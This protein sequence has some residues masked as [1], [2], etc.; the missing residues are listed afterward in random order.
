[1]SIQPF[2]SMANPG[3]ASGGGGSGLMTLLM[4]GSV[5]A[6]F[7]FMILRPQ[8]KQADQRKAMIEALKRGDK[9]VTSG[10]L[11]AV[12]RDV[13][14]DRVVATIGENI[15]VEIAKHAISGVVEQEEA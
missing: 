10:G 14:G 12:V 1:M 11:F 3:G 9:I 5:F 7:W 2:L 15:K 8:K 13:K 6:I 4:F